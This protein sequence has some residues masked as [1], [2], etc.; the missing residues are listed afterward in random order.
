MMFLGQPGASCCEFGGIDH[1]DSICEI[2]C[3]AAADDKLDALLRFRQ[4]FAKMPKIRDALCLGYDS[5]N[6]GRRC[7]SELI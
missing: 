4:A 7:F 6:S 5:D 3:D 2:S 1:L